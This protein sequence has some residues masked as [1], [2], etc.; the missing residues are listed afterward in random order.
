MS[1]AGRTFGFTCVRPDSWARETPFP[2]VATMSDTGRAVL[3]GVVDYL[4]L[5]PAERWV[6][7]VVADRRWRWDELAGGLSA[8]VWGKR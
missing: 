6:G 2:R 3:D 1:V 7:G 4:S 5:G 8:R